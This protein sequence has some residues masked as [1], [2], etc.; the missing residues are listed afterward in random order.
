[1]GQLDVSDVLLDAD[2]LDAITLIHRTSTTDQYGKNQLVECGTPT[3]GCVQPASG[4]TIQRLPEALRV[5][6]VSSFWIQGKIVSDGA[7][8]Y[9]DIIVFNG[10]RYAVQVVFDYTNYGAGFCE[11][12]CVRQRP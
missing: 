4:K 5:A 8:K 7:C 6:D 11:G 1:M 12:T 10:C 9:P 3:Y 2:F